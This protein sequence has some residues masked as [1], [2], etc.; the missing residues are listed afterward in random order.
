MP[1]EQNNS[2]KF[3]NEICLAY[4]VLMAVNAIYTHLY[5]ISKQCKVVL[6][7]P[8][9]HMGDLRYSSTHY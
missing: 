2:H 3:S 8:Q 5:L 6:C 1:S 7:M 9:W 4:N